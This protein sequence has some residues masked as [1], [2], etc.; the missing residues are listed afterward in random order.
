MALSLLPHAHVAARLATRNPPP[1][2]STPT[3]LR[4]RNPNPLQRHSSSSSDATATSTALQCPHFQSCSGCTHE[5]NLD[6]PPVIEEAT[7][8]FKSLGVSDFTFESGR[9]VGVP[10]VCHAF[11]AQLLEWHAYD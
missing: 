2:A 1:P 10:S 5:W 7:E 9:L 6:R 3:L 11:F 4:R 8:F